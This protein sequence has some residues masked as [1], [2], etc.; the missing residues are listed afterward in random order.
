MKIKREKKKNFRIT[1]SCSNTFLGVFLETFVVCPVHRVVYELHLKYV[2]EF[3]SISQNLH[4]SL[5][6]KPGTVN[7]LVN[8][9]VYLPLMMVIQ[10]GLCWFSSSTSLWDSYSLVFLVSNLP[11]HGVH[12]T[13]ACLC[14]S[15]IYQLMLNNTSVSYRNSVLFLFQL[16]NSVSIHPARTRARHAFSPEE[17]C[18]I[19]H[20]ALWGID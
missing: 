15:F 9:L 17:A 18:L 5:V 2:L 19:I 6:Y 8:E 4:A 10:A 14:W 3:M 13:V 12:Y 1:C 7:E 16:W 20:T 11:T